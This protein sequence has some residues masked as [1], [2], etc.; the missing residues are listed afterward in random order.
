MKK[1]TPDATGGTSQTV[2]QD[3]CL[4][5]RETAAVNDAFFWGS[6]QEV[7]F[8]ENVVN[9]Y[10]SKANLSCTIGSDTRLSTVFLPVFGPR[11]SPC[12]CTVSW[13]GETAESVTLQNNSSKGGLQVNAE[14]VERGQVHSLRDGDMIC[15]SSPEVAP[16]TSGTPDEYLFIYHH[17]KTPCP[18]LTYLYFADGYTLGSGGQGS[19]KKVVKR[20]TDQMYAVKTVI[21]TDDNVVRRT[22]KEIQIMKRLSHPGICQLYER[23]MEMD[24]FTL[25]MDYMNGGDLSTYLLN[26]GPMAEPDAKN[27]L[28]QVLSAV[29]YI[30][31]LNIIHADIKPENIL[32][33]RDKPLRAKLCDFGLADAACRHMRIMSRRGT[34]AY[35]APEVWSTV[36]FNGYDTKADCWS[37]GVTMFVMLTCKGL[38][39]DKLERYDPGREIKWEILGPVS[40]HG[41]DLLQ[42]LLEPNPYRRISVSDGLHHAWF[43]PKVPVST[44]AQNLSTKR[45]MKGKQSKV[46]KASS[47]HRCGKKY[48]QVKKAAEKVKTKKKTPTLVIISYTWNIS[49]KAC[50]LKK[51]S[52]T[53]KDPRA[54]EEDRYP[55]MDTQKHLQDRI[56][57]TNSCYTKLLTGRLA[58]E[59]DAAP[60]ELINVRRR[61]E[62]L[63][64]CWTIMRRSLNVFLGKEAVRQG[65]HTKQSVL[66]STSVLG[67][68]RVLDETDAEATRP[69][70]KRRRLSR[71]ILPASRQTS[72]H[73]TYLFLETSQDRESDNSFT[74]S[75]SSVDIDPSPTPLLSPATDYTAR[76]H[77]FLSNIQPNPRSPPR[78]N[79]RPRFEM[80]KSGFRFNKGTNAYELVRDPAL[81]RA[82]E[83]RENARLPYSTEDAFRIFVEVVGS[84]FEFVPLEDYFFDPN[85]LVVREGDPDYPPEFV[86]WAAPVEEH[87]GN[88]D[89]LVIR[90][91]EEGRINLN[92]TFDY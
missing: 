21:A 78:S 54:L 37:L 43:G 60:K 71:P 44:Q 10:L 47:C 6:L 79:G 12:H 8:P 53:K 67:K 65:S 42:G 68:R 77:K 83:E 3:C 48:L 27:I 72:S 91:D 55:A 87:D 29:T 74:P 63:R 11:I 64:G 25:V 84:A 69:R 73:L 19:V 7:F 85:E 61:L 9:L 62:K 5:V 34:L 2:E 40:E 32:L 82:A 56:P 39:G 59:I 1:P 38:H 89:G 41:R 90:R 26:E 76:L 23:F 20:T 80:G 31:S 15:F 88:S 4:R 51:Y 66:T 75:Q 24:R 45:Q 92:L 33:S 86:Q 50:E 30:H 36:L 81:L 16:K 35:M 70:F 58:S 17:Q 57:H 49:L 28:S 52:T 22:L 14:P 18:P 13:D 46:G